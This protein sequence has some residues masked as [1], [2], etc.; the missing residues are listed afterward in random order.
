MTR[1][2][3]EDVS[4]APK[5]RS[6]R[7]AHP[8]AQK[9]RSRF[10]ATA[11]LDR[12]FDRTPFTA[13]VHARDAHP[14][15][16]ITLTA[17]MILPELLTLVEP[18][19]KQIGDDRELARAVEADSGRILGAEN[20]AILAILLGIGA[21]VY[22]EAKFRGCYDRTIRHLA[23]KSRDFDDLEETYGCDG[24]DD[25]VATTIVLP[26]EL[27]QL[28]RRT[29][30]EFRTHPEAVLEAVLHR[31]LT[32]LAHKQPSDSITATIRSRWFSHSG[33]EEA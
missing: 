24:D 25:R 8:R 10:N 7:G 3:P 28:I 33:T 6:K 18:Y 2:A 1:P 11:I 4:P 30:D 5:P 19:G 12:V 20:A 22:D 16:P 23:I 27:L 31:A 29:A 14:A 15:R 17:A 21:A 32:V 13:D 9:R 26:F